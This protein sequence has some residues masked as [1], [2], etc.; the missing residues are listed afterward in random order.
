MQKDLAG[1]AYGTEETRCGDPAVAVVAVADVGGAGGAEAGRPLGWMC[2]CPCPCP[3]PCAG[4]WECAVVS[5][6]SLSPRLVEINQSIDGVIVVV[7]WYSCFVLECRC[8][9]EIRSREGE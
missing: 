6:L 9:S 5:A 8:M 1:G 2:P 4:P 7:C 3:Y